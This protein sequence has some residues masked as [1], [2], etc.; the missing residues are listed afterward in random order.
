MRD[1]LPGPRTRVGAARAPGGGGA[2]AGRA[3]ASSPRCCPTT[4]RMLAVF[5]DAGYAPTTSLDDG[6]LRLEFEI[7]PTAGA[8]CAVMEA[9][10]HRAEARSV[11]R[12]SPRRPSRCSGRGRRPS[13]GRRVVLRQPRRQPASPARSTWSTR[14]AAAG[15]TIAGRADVRASV[16]DIAE[17]VDLAVVAVPAE[18]TC[19]TWSPTA[20]R[21]ASARSSWSAAGF[22]ETGPEGRE[23]Q[24]RTGRQ[25][26]HAARHARASGRTASGVINTDPAVRLNASLSPVIP[27]RGR[28]GFFSPVRRARDRAARDGGGAR[29]RGLDVRLRRATAPTSA[30]TT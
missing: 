11:E 8:R 23:R 4:H 25:A 28:I 13:L 24:R 30:A 6:V 27:G 22:A 12:L 18:R 14:T 29:A 3:T 7:A 19:S 15:E 16:A 20:P 17:P 26:A 21:T 1:D 10:E 2:R 5:R 9:R